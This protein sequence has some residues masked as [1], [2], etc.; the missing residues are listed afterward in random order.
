MPCLTLA[1]SLHR[2]TVHGLYCDG[3]LVGTATSVKPE[4]SLIVAGTDARRGWARR[5]QVWNRIQLQ[6][7]ERIGLPVA[8]WL[9]PLQ[10]GSRALYR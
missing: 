4:E 2:R 6:T 9:C 7:T 10:L 8:C 3:Q 1:T 5:D